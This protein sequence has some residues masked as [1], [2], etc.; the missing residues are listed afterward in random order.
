MNASRLGQR[1]IAVGLGVAVAVIWP[2]VAV[3]SPAERATTVHVIATIQVG[4]PNSGTNQVAVSPNGKFAYV[5]EA[6]GGWLSVIDTAARKHIADIQVGGQNSHTDAV[7]VSP[8]G[9]L[10]YVTET[11]ADVVSVIDTATNKHIADV[12]L[13]TGGL[14]YG[15]DFG[16]GNFAYVAGLNSAVAMINSL[17]N[18]VGG[19]IQVTGSAIG[20]VD[21]HLP[22]VYVTGTSLARGYGSPVLWQ[23]DPATKQQKLAD[24]ITV[25]DPP[26]PNPPLVGPPAYT[27]GGLAV[28]GKDAYVTLTQRDFLTGNALSYLVVIN[29][30]TGKADATIPYGKSVP[31]G[32]ALSVPSG[33]LALVA[34]GNGTVTV[35]DTATNSVIDTVNVGGWAV[36]VAFSPN[37][38][39][40]YVSNKNGSVSVLS[41]T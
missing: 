15:V 34:N 27:L 12:R 26:L 23:I 5:T 17:T 21:A 8:D 37:G 13:G 32:V 36:D 6:G 33:R 2:G 16:L 7:A 14:V 9:K 4:G 10:V 22:V 24:F 25:P 18:T 1:V 30:L 3:A 19:I 38:T 28:G 35:I 40:A 29:T 11:S 31:G 39:V 20:N 41:I